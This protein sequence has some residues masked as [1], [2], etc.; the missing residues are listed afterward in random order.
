MRRFLAAWDA[1]WNAWEHWSMKRPCS[2]VV[3]TRRR[4]SDRERQDFQDIADGVSTAHRKPKR[5]EG[6]A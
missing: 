6:Q 1:F 3:W 4:L 2:H 5:Q